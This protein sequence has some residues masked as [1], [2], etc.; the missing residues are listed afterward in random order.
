MICGVQRLRL[1]LQQAYTGPAN[2][3]LKTHEYSDSISKI[4]SK[5]IRIAAK[6]GFASSNFHKT[7][8]NTSEYKRILKKNHSFP[9]LLQNLFLKAHA[10]KSEYKRIFKK[11]LAFHSFCNSFSLKPTLI[12]ANTQKVH[13]APESRRSRTSS[14]SSLQ[15]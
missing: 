11:T 7:H 2:K 14:H 10:N 15:R 1:P 5:P 13:S 12:I 9:Q 4:L 6:Y 3:L 8:A